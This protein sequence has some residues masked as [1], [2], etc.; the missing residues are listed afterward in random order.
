ME[1]IMMMDCQVVTSLLLWHI[2]RITKAYFTLA[3]IPC[4]KWANL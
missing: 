4:I 1:F 3:N 2:D